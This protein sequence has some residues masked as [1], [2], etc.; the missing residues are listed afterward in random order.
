MLA[1]VECFARHLEQRVQR[2]ALPGGPLPMVSLRSVLLRGFPLE[3]LLLLLLLQRGMMQARVHAMVQA[4]MVGQ[5]VRTSGVRDGASSRRGG[6]AE[7]RFTDGAGHG[8]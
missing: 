5:R 8:C 3:L 7:G 4:M 1:S 6:T 2:A